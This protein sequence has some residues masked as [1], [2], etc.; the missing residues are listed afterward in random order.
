M[1]RSSE[2]GAIKKTAEIAHA[3]RIRSD[4]D[5]RAQLKDPVCG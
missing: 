1:L 3:N 4:F 2:I 5:P